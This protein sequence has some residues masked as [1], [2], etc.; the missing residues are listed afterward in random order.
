MGCIVVLD[1]LPEALDLMQEALAHLHHDIHTFQ[2]P[3][4]ALAL[5]ASQPVDLLILDV[6]MPAMHGQEV[7]QNLHHN[8]HPP[9]PKILLFCGARE[10]GE[11]LRRESPL[12]VHD[13]IPKPFSL[14]ALV[15]TVER[16]MAM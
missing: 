11:A 10:E 9:H 13:M 7:L 5:M 4:A 12:P 1:D 3:H 16:L 14:S 8:G 15:A 2:D 6:R